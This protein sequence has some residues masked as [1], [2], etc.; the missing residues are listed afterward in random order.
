[1]KR[2]R[3]E[4]PSFSH[5][6]VSVAQI[7]ESVVSR[8]PQSWLEYKAKENP[9]HISNLPLIDTSG[10]SLGNTPRSRRLCV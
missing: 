9:A 3:P 6:L 4:T 10:N 2:P 1:M 5:W 8:V 7:A